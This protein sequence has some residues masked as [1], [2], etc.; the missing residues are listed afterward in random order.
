M[1]SLFHFPNK[2]DNLVD[3]HP[4]WSSTFPRIRKVAGHV[5]K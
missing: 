2:I 3:I 1:V 4:R 5:N